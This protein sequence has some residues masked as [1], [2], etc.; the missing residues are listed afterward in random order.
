[1]IF[2]KQIKNVYMQTAF[3]RCDDN[4]TAYYFSSDDFNDLNRQEFDFESSLGHTLKGNFYYYENYKENILVV[5]DHGFG[6]GHKSYMKEIERLCQAGYLVF[7]YDHTGCM[8]SGGK[9]ANGMA[10]SLHDLDDAYKALKAL[11][12]LKGF[13]FY[14]I[15]HSWGGFSTLNISALHKEIKKVVVLSGF[16]KVEHMI[17]ANFSGLLKGYRKA[18]MDLEESANPDYINFDGVKSL[19]Q[20]KADALLIYSSN[21]H[22]CNKEVHYDY[23]YENLKDEKNV[24][25]VLVDNKRHNPNYTTNAVNLLTD[26]LTKLEKLTKKKK[27]VTEEQKQEFVNSFNWDEM[28]K[29]DE[30]IWEMILKHFEN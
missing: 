15:G 10:Q 19:K 26:Y 4:H 9:N 6:G 21:D 2:E 14:S 13:T 24:K 12:E 8:E 17:N 20:S 22:L 23:L 5:F 7:A 3:S 18:I 30:S 28:T 27:L 25:F 11:D 16:A 29:Q 1:M